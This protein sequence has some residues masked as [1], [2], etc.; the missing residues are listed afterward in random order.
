MARTADKAKWIWIARECHTPDFYLRAR[1]TFRLAAK[2]AQARLRVTA[3]SE[4]ALYVNGQYV[5]GGPAPSSPEAPLYDT[6]TLDDLPLARG[7]N[8]LAVIAHNY[9]V[10]LPRLPR[11]SG[12]LW[13]QLDVTGADGRTE[14]IATDRQWRVAPAEDFSRRAPRLYWTAGFAEVRD[15][16]REPAGW[17]AFR[18]SE[19]RWLKADEVRPARQEGAPPPRVAERPG[20][21]LLETFELPRDVVATGRV[22]WPRGVTAIP[23]EFA[24]PDVAHGEFYAGSFVHIKTRMKARLLFDCDE[25]AAVYVNNHQVIRQ[26]YNEDF[27]YWLSDEEQD[28][29]TGIHRGQGNR[30]E[31]AEVSLDPGWNS[32]GVVIY[33]P[34]SSWGFAMRFDDPKTGEPLPLAFSPDMK[35]GEMTDWHIVRD[36]LCPCGNGSLPDTPSPNERTFPD[37][38]YQ[39]AWEKPTRTRAAGRG[40]AA[41]VA[42]SRTEGP[43]VLADGEFVVYDFGTEVVGRAEIDVEGPAGAIL[44]VAWSEDVDE[45]SGVVSVRRGMRR[46]DRLI[47]RGERQTVRFFNR[48]TLRY[49]ELVARNGEGELKIRRLGIHATGAEPPALPEADDADLSATMT[50]IGR[51][52]RCCLQHTLEGSPAREAEQSIPAAY[53]LAQAERTFY[54]RTVL[55]EQALRGFAED[56]HEDGFFRSIVPAGT[57][58]TVP[59]W[60][61]LWIIWLAEHVAWTGD[62]PLAAELLPVAGKCIDWTAQFHDTNG[63]LENKGDRRPWWLFVDLSPIDKRGE[64]TAWQALYARALRA[65]AYVADVAGNEETAEHSLAEARTVCERASERLWDDAR[66]LF[67]DTRLFEHLS[68]GAS[69]A[70]NYYALYGGLASDEQADRLLGNLWK[71]TAAE[72]ADWGPRQNPYVK[73]FALEALLERGQAERALTMIRTYWGAMAKAGLA[74]VPEIFPLPRGRDG[75]G[76]DGHVEGPYAR[77]PPPVL[78]HGW[79]VHPAALVAKW[80]LG[81][82]PAGPGFEPLLLAPMPGDLTNLSGRAWTP[83][84]PVEV[85]IGRDDRGRR[86]RITVPGEMPY[87]L[88]RR[89]LSPDDEVEVSGGK[90]VKGK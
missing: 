63:L 44:D 60:N 66:G 11:L 25:A 74:T 71:G 7:P 73:Y 4:Y 35:S 38:A 21:R 12:G 49:L 82:Q 72:A 14:T 41:L 64:V 75:D 8:I 22:A 37:P 90:A 62:K 78:C 76:R 5:G 17:T 68:P 29:Y 19:K 43:L 16:R 10:G 32:L 89:H 69:P 51:T 50:L 87:R 48:R 56:Q 77:Q 31:S 79:G 27:V 3:L 61:L 23:F 2:P 45:D 24:V 34:G 9:H 55:G 81:V 54:G 47:L 52:L 65:A 26:G 58:H 46:A 88:D 18:F 36:Q 57:V 30:I 67:V 42:E 70:S 39:L 6:Y 80:I 83:K 15:T 40:A 85:A 84:G 53:L 59:D 28:D 13:L 20:P 86:I 1:R 33:D